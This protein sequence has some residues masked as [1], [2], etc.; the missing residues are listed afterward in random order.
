MLQKSN[1]IFSQHWSIQKLIIELYKIK[2]EL[3]PLVI[4]SGI[5]KRNAFYGLEREELKHQKRITVNIFK[6]DVRKWIS[7]NILA[8]F[9]KCLY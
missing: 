7:M 6:S 8:D 5:S 1:D 2:S 4:V 3:A 9:A